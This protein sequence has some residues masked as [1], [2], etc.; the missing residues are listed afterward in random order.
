MPE[1]EISVR[2]RNCLDGQWGYPDNDVPDPI[3]TDIYSVASL[4]VIDEG[5][6]KGNLYSNQEVTIL[7]AEFELDSRWNRHNA[8]GVLHIKY[9]VPD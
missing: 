5:R 8:P 1:Y 7:K 4:H 3:W 2:R 6:D 9:S